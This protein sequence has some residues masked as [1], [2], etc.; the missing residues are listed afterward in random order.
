MASWVNKPKSELSD[1]S[2]TLESYFTEN[3]P[4]SI[5]EAAAKIEEITGIK[6]GETQVRKF[7][8]SLG[9]RYIKSCSVP[10]KSLTE[11]KKKNKETIWKKISNPY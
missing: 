8:K 4:S 11:E 9:F 7:I 6:R 10:A 5:P 1:Y 3:P 2:E